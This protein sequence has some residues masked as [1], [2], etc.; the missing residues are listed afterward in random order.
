MELCTAQTSYKKRPGAL[1]LSA[2]ELYWAPATSPTAHELSV[3]ATAM[4]ALF[5]SK[6]GGARVM[7]KIAFTPTRAGGDDS[8]NFTFTAAAS[9]LSD[10]EKF[11]HEISTMIARNREREAT[12]QTGGDA[13]TSGSSTPIPIPNPN[14]AKASVDPTGADASKSSS[15]G[16]NS[17]TAAPANN[18]FRLR[19]QVLQASPHLLALHRELVLSGQLTELE[20]WQGREDLLA[21]VAAEENLLKGKSGEMVDPKTVTGQNGQV[22]VKITPMLIRE[23]F[24]EFPVVLKAY[25]DN[26]PDPLDEAAFWTRYFQSKLFNRNRTTNRAAVDA[27]K[28]DPIFD[29]YLG[30]EDDDIVPQNQTDHEIYRLL[31][32]AATEQDQHEITN[33][34]QDYTMKAGGQRASLPLMR[35]FNEHSER[36]LSQALGSTASDR[37]YVNPGNAGDRNYY[38]EIELSDLSTRQAPDRISLI[39][40]NRS[41]PNPAS[42]ATL[43]AGT[44]T[45]EE[46]LSVENAQVGEDDSLI[47][48]AQKRER[49]K[50]MK[51]EIVHDWQGRLNNFRVDAKAARAG[52]RDMMDNIELQTERNRKTTGSNGLPRAQLLTVES[53]STTTLEFLR[54]FWTSILPPRPNDIS[55]F[56]TAP[57][58]ERNA[59]ATKFKAYLEKSRERIER[60]IEDAAREGPDVGKRVQAALEPIS[61]SIEAAIKMYI[62]KLG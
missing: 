57:V 33:L 42:V 38:S 45:S 25:N 41:G 19:K 2:T 35:R 54:H 6:E 59:R 62:T 24:E 17:A 18:T 30:Q 52:M 51:D 60:A 16:T 53:I 61:D 3:P 20:F 7:L 37:T 8:Y 48:L 29:K 21:Q 4:T 10:R 31:D 46:T 12:A 39:L 50:K 43:T 27:I 11:K 47:V 15:A 36:L 34:P 14:S 26:V 1:H 5:A 58:V 13:P 44:A 23:I 40:Q 22:T 55:P 32:L 28:D 9:A 56:A 49:E